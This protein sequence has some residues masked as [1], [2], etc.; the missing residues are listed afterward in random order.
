[1]GFFFSFFHICSELP[2]VWEHPRLTI[3]KVISK[4]TYFLICIFSFIFLFLLSAKDVASGRG[5]SIR[6]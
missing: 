4:A 6:L 5:S 3:D 2:A 1:M